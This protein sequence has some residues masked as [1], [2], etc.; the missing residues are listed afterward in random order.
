[1]TSAFPIT[2]TLSR[3]PHLRQLAWLVV[4]PV[5]T[6]VR[7]YCCPIGQSAEV[8]SSD[9]HPAASHPSMDA[10]VNSRVRG[11]NGA[12]DGGDDGP[13]GSGR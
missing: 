3:A 7:S 10:K 4:F 1:M 11:Q 8:R 12:P 13:E 6:A 9:G 5:H 2:P